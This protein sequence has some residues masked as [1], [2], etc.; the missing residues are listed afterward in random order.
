MFKRFTIN[1]ILLREVRGT[2]R[3]SQT[4][5]LLAGFIGL[6]SG[7]TLL[8]YASEF[9]NS[10][11]STGQQSDLGQTIFLILMMATILALIFIPTVKAAASIAGERERKTFDLLLTSQLSVTAIIFGKML[12][13]LAYCALLLFAMTPLVAMTFLI[14]GVDVGSLIIIYLIIMAHVVLHTSIG[15]YWSA[16][17]STATVAIGASLASIIGGL[18]VVPAIAFVLVLLINESIVANQTLGSYVHT[19]LLA[20]NPFFVV[21]KTVEDIRVQETWLVTLFVAGQNI[22]LPALW[23]LS[24]LGCWLAS[25]G[26]LY[27]SIRTIR[28]HRTPQTRPHPTKEGA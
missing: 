11:T 24:L 5:W 22:S 6:I 19:L 25:I 17:F 15:I 18:L 16:R 26:L 2:M 13:T 9:I 21:I 3:V 23:I 27:A 1:P 10:P 14:G 7:P 8:V 28:N 12:A 4:F 20:G